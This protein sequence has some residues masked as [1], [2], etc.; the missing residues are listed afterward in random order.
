M[1]IS[2]ENIFTV[3]C[4]SVHF[5]SYVCTHFND[6]HCLTPFHRLLH[7]IMH[8]HAYTYSMHIIVHILH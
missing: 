2:F 6:L 4:I 1:C 5:F 7:I 8:I 3:N